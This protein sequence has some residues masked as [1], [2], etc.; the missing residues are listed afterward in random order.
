MT[1]GV[2]QESQENH[3]CKCTE[4]GRQGA[5]RDAVHTQVCVCFMLEAVGPA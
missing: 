5:G 4:K 1:K 3:Q 2:E